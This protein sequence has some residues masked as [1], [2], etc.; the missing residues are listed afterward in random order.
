MR[1]TQSAV[2]LIGLLAGQVCS[3]QVPSRLF[4]PEGH[5][6]AGVYYFPDDQVRR[7]TALHDVVMPHIVWAK[8]LY[9]GRLQSSVAATFLRYFSLECSFF[10]FFCG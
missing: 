2:L 9:S 6:K 3:Q 5:G 1:Q 7:L 10:G 8:P 4:K